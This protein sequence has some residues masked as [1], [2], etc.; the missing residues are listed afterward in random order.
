MFEAYTFEVSRRTRQAQALHIT[1]KAATVAGALTALSRELRAIAD[2][3]P[4][5]D[6]RL[7]A[8]GADGFEI[9]DIV[10]APYFDQRKRD[11]DRH[12][13]QTFTDRAYGLLDSAENR[14]NRISGP[15]SF[16]VDPKTP[17]GK[18]IR[19]AR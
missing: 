18:R 4:S 5:A 1:V 12:N 14:A 17:M 9:I 10:G 6:A 11:A 16:S 7:V 2:N 19:P 13:D 15:L 8:S 3:A